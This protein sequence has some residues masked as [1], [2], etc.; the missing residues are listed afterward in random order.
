MTYL[1]HWPTPGT[2]GNAKIDFEQV[3]E[4]V[5]QVLSNLGDIHKKL[6]PSIH[7]T[8]TNGKGSCAVIISNILRKNGYTVNSFTSPH[9]HHCNERINID[10]IDISDSYLYDI[11]EK[12][13]IA[14]EEKPI[15]FFEAMTIMSIVAFFENKSDFNIFEV[16]MGAR[17]DATNI[18]E[19][20]A[21]SVITPISYDHEEYLGNTVAKIAFEK[22]HIIKPNTPL[23]IGPQP[24]EATQM[25]KI[26]AQDQN[27]EMSIYGQDFTIETNER[28]SFDFISKIRNISNIGKPS[29]HGDHQYI[30]NSI[31]IA[32]ALKIENIE[33]DD[34]KLKE[35]IKSTKWPN[36]LEKISNNLNS[37]I[38]K[39]SDIYI[40]S[41][42]NNAGA[43]ALS[44]WLDDES[45]KDSKPTK[46]I[47]I[48]GFSRTKCKANFLQLLHNSC[49]HVFATRVDGEPNPEEIEAICNVAKSQKID[50]TG[51]AD[52]LDCFELIAKKYQNEKVRV[53][54]CGSIH[55]ARDVKKFG[56]A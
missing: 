5:G 25:I 22:A 29:L 47:A 35:A 14:N 18:I 51:A 31:A 30:N 15:T 52:L 27:S 26:I 10:G 20:R 43:Y 6:S 48:V 42:H 17:I 28:G 16:G 24:K 11:A 45:Q 2:F 53:V 40:D 3:F 39:E 41:A 12:V 32:T 8:G 7:I 21:A 34:N 49:E 19:N 36:R 23:I 56:R 46:N 37:F 38:S 9:I 1:P 13:R 55:L 4:R 44:K 33:I 54:I 50:V